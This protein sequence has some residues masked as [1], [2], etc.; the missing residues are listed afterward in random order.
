MGPDRSH[1]LALCDCSSLPSRPR[2]CRSGGMRGVSIA[3]QRPC[4]LKQAI[5]RVLSSFHLVPP[6][7]HGPSTTTLP[8]QPASPGPS[9][10]HWEAVRRR[11][12]KHL[13][14]SGKGGDAI[15]DWQPHHCT[16]KLNCGRLCPRATQRLLV[17]ER[18]CLG[19]CRARLFPGGRHVT[20]YGQ[21][22]R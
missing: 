19:C 8:A 15:S 11:V 3:A 1:N 22:G 4:E 14:V 10:A 7:N 5:I 20:K 21:I 6:R 2:D 17:T 13:P 9:R 18:C 16:R 12:C